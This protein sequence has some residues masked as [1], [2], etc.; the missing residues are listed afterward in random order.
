MSSRDLNIKLAN[1]Q[2][3]YILFLI[4]HKTWYA[5][6]LCAISAVQSE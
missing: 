5:P 6:P 1:S 4:N 3:A 2:E